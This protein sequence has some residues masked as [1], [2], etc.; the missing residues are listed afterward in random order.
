MKESP[1]EVCGKQ[2]DIEVK[3][4]WNCGSIPHSK[5]MIAKVLHKTNANPTSNIT[6]EDLQKWRNVF[7]KAGPIKIIVHPSIQ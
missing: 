7:K 3:T 6:E 2:N 1:C 4:C 5:T